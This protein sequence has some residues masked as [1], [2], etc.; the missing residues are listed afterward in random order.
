MN[1]IIIGVPDKGIREGLVEK[2]ISAVA[3]IQES[4]CE[5]SFHILKESDFVNKESTKTK[6]V[7]LSENVQA[8]CDLVKVCCRSNGL[9]KF[10]P[11]SFF[12]A[13]T[14]ML[15]LKT[16]KKEVLTGI[17]N[18]V[19]SENDILY[20]KSKG[21]DSVPTLCKTALESAIYF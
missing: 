18:G 21:L 12:K 6:K 13:L 20:L 19:Y 14:E 1:L 17:I 9:T 10:T 7:I 3:G 15:C 11:F 16:I 4:E 5:I 2:I 8:V